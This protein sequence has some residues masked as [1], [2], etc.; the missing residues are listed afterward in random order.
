MQN[1]TTFVI[2]LKGERKMV[3]YHDGFS[4]RELIIE[5]GKMDSLVLLWGMPF[6]FVRGN[7]RSP[8]EDIPQQKQNLIVSKGFY[9]CQIFGNKISV[10][11][12]EVGGKGGLLNDERVI[13]KNVLDRQDNIGERWIPLVYDEEKKKIFW[14]YERNNGSRKITMRENKIGPESTQIAEFAI[15]D[16]VTE[17]TKRI[18]RVKKGRFVVIQLGN[19]AFLFDSI[20]GTHLFDAF[21]IF[22][23]GYMLKDVI[24]REDTIIMVEKNLT[25]SDVR[26]VSLDIPKTISS[27]SPSS[28]SIL[29]EGKDVTSWN[30]EDL[31]NNEFIRARESEDV[32]YDRDSKSLYPSLNLSDFFP[33]Q[34]RANDRVSPFRDIDDFK[35]KGGII[36]RGYDVITRG[37]LGKNIF[38]FE[39][40]K[41]IYYSTL[42]WIPED[43]KYV[44]TDEEIIFFSLSDGYCFAKMERDVSVLSEKRSTRG[45]PK[46]LSKKDR[47]LVYTDDHVWD[48]YV[49]EYTFRISSDQRDSIRD[50]AVDDFGRIFTPF[51]TTNQ[52]S[53]VQGVAELSL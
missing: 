50:L 5:D 4:F 6:L 34:K 32:R 9:V 44:F 28:P 48:L 41:M 23:T 20:D 52:G 46:F 47:R 26:L 40:G 24:V 45:I 21:G 51:R 17:D 29:L 43:I 37:I 39:D 33:S 53:I 42:D 35:V 36:A 27:V 3:I 38:V 10:Y 30:V 22:P 25:H 8:E 31:P 2:S 14:I 12:T 18:S 7:L 15:P 49:P 1:D 13:F 11:R 19:T 16:F